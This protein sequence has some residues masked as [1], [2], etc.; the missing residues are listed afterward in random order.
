MN[1][2]TTILRKTA[3][4]LLTFPLI[5]LTLPAQ[6][7]AGKPQ[8][9]TIRTT[10]HQAIQEDTS[11][12]A[13]AIVDQVHF[14]RFNRYGRKLVENSLKPD[15][16][17]DRKII[18]YYDEK[19]RVK[20][21]V[22]IT[23]K[24]GGVDRIFQY[25]YDEKGRVN[26]KKILDTERNVVNTDTIIRN[27]AGQVVKRIHN[28]TMIR[29]TDKQQTNYQETVEIKYNKQG[30]AVNVFEQ[31]T[32]TKNTRN[33]GR[34]LAKRDTLP[35]TYYSE[36][37]FRRFNAP[38]KKKVNLV[39]DEFGNW[40]KRTEYN[41]VNPEYIV[42]RSIE[43]DENISDRD[44][45]HLKG[46]VRSVKQTSYFAVP[47]TRS[48]ILKG[49]KKGVFFTHHLDREGRITSTEHFSETGIPL[50]KTDYVYDDKNNLQKEV[51]KSP[52]GKTISTILWTSYDSNGNIRNKTLLDAEG[53]VLRKGI[54]RYDYE[55]NC[56]IEAW[57][58]ADGTKFNHFAYQYD[59]YG[60]QISKQ[61]VVAP[62]GAEGTEYEPVK[63]Q[64]NA[65]GRLVEEW[66]GTP[67]NTRHYTYIYNKQGEVISGTESINEGAAAKFIYKFYNDPQ[68][69]WKKRIKFVDDKPTIYEERQYTYY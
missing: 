52:Q 47:K 58:N 20:E 14:V 4:L 18:Y 32:L 56:I 50:G 35:L 59:S 37:A 64:W 19:G 1:N 45:L 3:F 6:K 24:A 69:N 41:G 26:G 43:Y 10:V 36:G 30:E 7:T 54:F 12:V 33:K 5:P 61:I 62:E 13:G 46:K 27:E 29:T 48:A 67:Q 42:V 51:H 40:V 39:Y 28:G 34:A 11:W 22:S 44:K 8:I 23:A 63:R 31:S 2:T 17:A 49:K 65:R 53:N 38:D 57:F 21:E 9:K 55:G 66:I 25:F 68:G 60:Q 16:S 15:G